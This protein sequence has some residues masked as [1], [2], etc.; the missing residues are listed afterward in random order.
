MTH[1]SPRILILTAADT[2]VLAIERARLRMPEGFPAVEVF[3]LRDF[4]EPSA[5]QSF[6]ERTLPGAAL[7][8]AH[9]LGGASYF[10]DG[11]RSLSRAC[12]ASGV[13][14]LALPHTGELDPELSALS[15]VALPTLTSALAYVTHGGVTNYEQLLRFLADQCAGT[16]FGADAPAA[17]QR[18]GVYVES[19]D[20]AGRPR[21]GVLFYRAHWLSGNLAWID[22]LTAELERAGCAVRAVFCE[23]L[24]ELDA[25]GMPAAVR[26]HMQDVDVLISTLAFQGPHGL[27][28]PVLQAIPSGFTHAEW[29]ASERGLPPRDVAMYLALPELDG[30]IITVPISFK[31]AG[32]LGV[33]GSEEIRCDDPLPDRAAH[34]A[35]MARAWCELRRT[36]PAER[37]VAV[38]LHNY[39]SRNSRIG[40]GVGL[41]APESAVR[42]LRELAAHGYQVAEHPQ[43]GDALI[44]ALLAGVTH[45]E[46]DAHPERLESAPLQLPL[47]RYLERFAELPDEVQQALRAHWGEPPGTAVCTA[48]GFPIPGL[49]LGNVFVGIQPPRG[50][51]VDRRAIFHSPD[52]PPPHFYL[53]YYQ[54]I[55]DVFG[56]H[57]IIHLGKHGNLEWLPGKGIGLS[58]RCY[59]EVALGAL[60]NIYPF[61]VNNPGEGTQAK[62]RTHAVIVDHLIPV[63]TRA[64]SYGAL[65]KLEQLADEYAQVSDLDP[66]KRPRVAEKILEVIRD[67]SIYRD[68]AYERPPGEEDL[69]GFL[70][71]LDGYLCEIKESQI[72]DGLHVLAELPE[73]EREVDL[74]A[75][76]VRIDQAG[77]RGLPAA[78]A[79]DLGLD[80]EKLRANP[81]ERVGVPGARNAA[82]VIEQLEAR[83]A[84]VVRT[85]TAC[86]PRSEE[87]L[88]FL[89]REVRPRLAR[90]PDELAHILRAL[91]GRFVP[92]GPAGA[93]TRGMASVLPTGR[94]FYAVDV[95]G[96]P[97][98]T[99]CEVGRRAA[100]AVLARHLA[101]TGTYPTSIGMVVWSTSNM[102]TGGDDIGEILHLLG[103]RPVWR[104]AN[105]RVVGLE[106]IPLDV[107]GRPRIDV[108]VRISGF[109]RDSF[110]HVVELLDDAVELVAGLDEPHEQNFVRAHAQ[111]EIAAGVPAS[112]ATARIFG[113]P[114][115]AYG[116]GI[117]QLID[118]KNWSSDTDLEQ[119]YVTWGGYAYGRKREGE[120]AFELFRQRLSS[121]QIALQNQDNRE[122]DIFDS[123]D[124]FQFHGGM[125]AAVRA[126]TGREPRAYLG[127]TSR[128][129]QVR[130][131]GL[132]EEAARVLR[133]RALNPKWIRSMQRHGYRGAAELAATVD[134]VF[135]YSATAHAIEPW[136]YDALARAYVLDDEVRGFLADK[137][138]RAL[139]DVIERL[140]EAAQRGLWAD[141]QSELLAELERVHLENEAA[142]EGE[143]A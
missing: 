53:A 23:S 141:P 52:L 8:F 65:L 84:Q 138:P 17:T 56:A 81:A 94:N 76:L 31:R 117:L 34:V 54:W 43:S 14:F 13:P 73:G 12:R 79:E 62:R 126:L 83:A 98:E 44:A 93:P 125:V 48:R 133:S 57:A 36:P 3:H 99:A 6:E 19:E 37:R 33:P 50:F 106:V 38:L 41:D 27:D 88:A 9:I 58:A 40:N 101:E 28:C 60:P 21:V 29:L 32:S 142:L 119:V 105:R 24:R 91:D 46:D 132:R 96:I 112:A 11:F 70:F 20:A 86:G 111:R 67:S 95:R 90:T 2:E 109:F 89:E 103:V 42:L 49:E 100:D 55:R 85:S 128:P 107:L 139:A 130:V 80:Y 4:R 122:H 59:P 10:G 118:Q 30:R 75:A 121:I 134:F 114:P 135:G 1:P 140:L 137:N 113:S 82:D 63:M 45:A 124:Y 92:P 15:S 71:A 25:S 123:D 143:D 116:A 77:V 26:E 69:E 61:I 64:D 131:R 51:G 22:A 74:L 78:I 115:G 87:T 72:R 127:D 5:W 66:V 16:Q 136:M 104:D 47:E 39:P 7:L 18:R 97:T 68:L 120:P 129:E 35:R 110:P 102:R 108:V